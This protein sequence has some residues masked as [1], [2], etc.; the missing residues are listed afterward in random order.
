MPLTTSFLF[1][2]NTLV[3]CELIPDPCQAIPTVPQPS[4]EFLSVHKLH[5][6]H[7]I[8]RHGDR[9]PETPLPSN[10]PAWD[11]TDVFKLLGLSG[12]STDFKKRY[13]PT[14]FTSPLPGSCPIGQLTALGFKQHNTLGWNLGKKYRPLLS[15]T[16]PKHVYI[17]ATNS[18]RVIQS[19]EANID[20]FWNFT[21]KGPYDIWILAGPDPLLPPTLPLICPTVSS[22]PVWTSPEVLNLIKI[23]SPVIHEGSKLFSVPPELFPILGL[24]D[25][26]I[27]QYCH[28]SSYPLP[29]SITMN[30]LSQLD[31]FFNAVVNVT[32]HIG[33]DFMADPL[34]FEMLNNWVNLAKNSTRLDHTYSLWSAH[35]ATLGFL[36]A[37]LELSNDIP[38]PPFASHLE[39]ELWENVKDGE[40]YIGAAY[41]GKYLVIPSCG[42][43]FCPF[44]NWYE[45]LHV[46]TPAEWAT[47]CNTKP[48]IVTNKWIV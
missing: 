6:A 33:T 28:N 2:L 46:L 35:D 32:Y 19:A 41:N 20:G 14:T 18:E 12:V 16:D 38:D 25:G 24:H 17:R 30:F 36:L 27:C 31:Q 7:V 47:K 44:L 39:L 21:Q 1:L 4:R 43:D 23:Y 48:D 34:I 29:P 11:C 5:A 9:T 37:G 15:L 8:T 40:F 13:L 42:K 22:I 3:A 10:Q 45:G 26:V